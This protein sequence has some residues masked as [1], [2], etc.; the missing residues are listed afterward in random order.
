MLHPV[1]TNSS[2]KASACAELRTNL[3]KKKI[4]NIALLQFH[5]NVTS[6]SVS[7]LLQGTECSIRFGDLDIIYS[8]TSVVAL[9]SIFLLQSPTLSALDTFIAASSEM[10]ALSWSEYTVGSLAQTAQN[11]VD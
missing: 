3:G 4:P 1:P 8:I 11:A 5:L 10:W 9:P 7:L 2:V 6:R